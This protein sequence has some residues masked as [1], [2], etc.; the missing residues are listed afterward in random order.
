M[1]LG[2]TARAQG[3]KQR[4]RVAAVQMRA[5]LGEVEAN[6]ES[7]E[8]WAR[9]ALREGARWIV[10]PEFFTTGIAYHPTRLLNAH[11]P[12]D[13]A[14]MQLL[15]SL[16]KEGQAYVAQGILAAD[17]A[18]AFAAVTLAIT[19]CPNVRDVCGF[20]AGTTAIITDGA[21]HHDLFESASTVVAARTLTDNRGFSQAYPA[22]STVIEIDQHTFSLSAHTDGSLSLIRETAAG[23][24]QRE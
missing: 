7:A 15:K 24:I 11:R 16:A 19:Q 5:T 1:V 20:S 3:R 8:R 23:A 6:L 10:L 4:V 13:G 2:G 17:Q 9:R 21:G 12:L 22:G 14:P 18:G